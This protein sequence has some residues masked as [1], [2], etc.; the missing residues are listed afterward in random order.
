MV[1]AGL[2]L[3]PGIGAQH[4]TSSILSEPV[5]LYFGEAIGTRDL[6]LLETRHDPG[7]ESWSPLGTGHR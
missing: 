5:R 3:W 7:R 2:I 6:A 4:L 1:M